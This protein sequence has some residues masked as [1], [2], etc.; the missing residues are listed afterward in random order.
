[1]LFSVIVAALET[2]RGQGFVRLSDGSIRND[3]L[4]SAAHRIPGL[5]GLSAE[6]EG[7]PG[8]VLRVS[9]GDLNFAP[10][11][12]IEQRLLM[13]FPPDAAPR[14]RQPVTLVLRDAAGGAELARIPSFAM[15]PAR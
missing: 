6:M 1:M 11:R 15:G 14:G 8:A 5:G 4:L 9:D 3:F 2:A 10:D 7:T 12:R 13:T